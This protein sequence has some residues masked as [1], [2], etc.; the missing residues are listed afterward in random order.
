MHLYL[1]CYLW[2]IFCADI[3]RPRYV[4][5]YWKRWANSSTNQGCSFLC[6]SRLLCSWPLSLS[7]SKRQNTQARMQLQGKVALAMIVLLYVIRQLI[8][9]YRRESNW[10]I[11]YLV[12]AF[13]IPTSLF[14]WT[15]K[16]FFCRHVFP[17]WK[18]LKSTTYSDQIS[19]RWKNNTCP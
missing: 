16:G 2:Y 19:N 11:L 14:A 18:K 5:W 3:R 9:N 13:S 17:P 8:S 4:S 12:L 7:F 15:K 6:L 1:F 10:W